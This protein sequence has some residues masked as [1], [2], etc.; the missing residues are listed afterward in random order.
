MNRRRI[1]AVLDHR[2]VGDGRF[3]AFGA[4]GLREDRTD[5][6]VA[7]AGRHQIGR[8]RPGQGHRVFCGLVAVT[9]AQ[10][11]LVARDAG[12]EDHAVGHRRT[13]GH[14]VSAVGAEHLGG[15]AFALADGAAV[16]E[17]R[18]EFTDGNRQVGTQQVLPEEFIERPACSAFQ[19]RGA[20]GMPRCVP[21]VFIGPGKLHQR[22]EHRRQR[23][24]TIALDGRQDA[25]AEEA[26]GV[27]GQPDEVVGVLHDHQRNARR[28]AAVADQEHRHAGIALAQA[29]Q[30]LDALVVALAF[31]HLPT[32]QHTLDGRVR[33][34]DRGGV[35]Q[36]FRRQHVNGA[37]FHVVDQLLQGATEDGALVRRAA[38]QQGQHPEGVSIFRH[39]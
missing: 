14:V 6:A 24:L 38:D 4:Q 23:G 18:T 36:G 5:D 8:Q 34:Q 20:T 17:Q 3:H 26:A 10:G 1:D 12:H 29:D 16:V 19:K 30:Q 28:G 15:V 9:V 21:G 7:V 37:L 33:A 11:D 2:I 27:L 32:E 13:V 31:I 39:D 35:A 25:A 22:P